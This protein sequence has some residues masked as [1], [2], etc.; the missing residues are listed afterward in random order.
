MDT[1][2]PSL[3]DLSPI[4]PCLS[5]LG[6]HRALGWAPCLYSSFPL[7]SYFTHSSVYVSILLSQFISPCVLL[8]CVHLFNAFFPNLLFCKLFQMNFRIILLCSKETSILEIH[9]ETLTSL[10]YWVFPSKRLTHLYL[11]IFYIFNKAF[12]FSL[13]RPCIFFGKI[14]CRHLCLLFPICTRFF[15]FLLY[16]L[17]EIYCYID[18]LLI[19]TYLFC[20]ESFY[21][22]LL[23]SSMCFQWILLSFMGLKFILTVNNDDFLFLSNNYTSCLCFISHYVS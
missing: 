9:L 6:H 5:P 21:W 18:K 19:F 22:I 16:P 20:N 12:W 4:S 10:C 11:V 2:V 7:A 13:Y 3:L 14:I 15:I 23:I 1:Y 17:S 8:P